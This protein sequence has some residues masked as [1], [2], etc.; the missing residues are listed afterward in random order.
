[1]TVIVISIV[2]CSILFE[3]CFHSANRVLSHKL[4]VKLQTDL[5]VF[6]R[7]SF[8]MEGLLDIVFEIIKSSLREPHALV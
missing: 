2:E 8:L 5:D 3:E 7:L 6:L 4:V 1:M